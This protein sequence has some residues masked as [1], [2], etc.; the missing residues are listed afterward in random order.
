MLACGEGKTSVIQG[1]EK[2]AEDISKYQET[3]LNFEKVIAFS[4]D[5]F[6]RL[7]LA[8][9]ITIKYVDKLPKLTK[10]LGVESIIRMFQIGRTIKQ[11]KDK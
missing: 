7:Y 4:L 2:L 1:L 8:G 6:V 11:G 3:I 9:I 10:D 5:D